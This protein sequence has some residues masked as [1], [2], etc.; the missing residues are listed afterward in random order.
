MGLVMYDYGA[1]NIVL[2]SQG[3]STTWA[4]FAK[5]VL[6]LNDETVQKVIMLSQI[7]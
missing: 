5:G 3:L 1:E 6:D 4:S 2:L 7:L